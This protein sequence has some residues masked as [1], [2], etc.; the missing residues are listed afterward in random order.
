MRPERYSQ[1]SN[2]LVIQQN[3]RPL[4]QDVGGEKTGQHNRKGNAFHER[5]LSRNS[6]LRN[7]GPCTSNPE[8]VFQSSGFEVHGP[9]FRSQHWPLDCFWSCMVLIVPSKTYRKIDYSTLIAYT[10]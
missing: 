2:P 7:S 5:Y 6:E 3:R 9:E 1:N 10:V 4:R 8:L